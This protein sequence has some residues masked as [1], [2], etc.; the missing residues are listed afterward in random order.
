VTNETRW[1]ARA[2]LD[3]SGE[4][5]RQTH[6]FMAWALCLA[7]AVIMGATQRPRVPLVD[8]GTAVEDAEVAR[9]Q[10]ARLWIALFMGLLAPTC[11]SILITRRRRRGGSHPRGIVIDVT[12]DGELRLWGR[13]YGQRLKLETAT[14][15]ERLVDV[16]AGR[17]GAWRQ[18]RLTITPM[19]GRPLELATVATAEDNDLVLV[20]FGGEGNCVELPREDYLALFELSHDL[21]GRGDARDARS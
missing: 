8:R 11:L 1:E 7:L 14:I 17:L 3:V 20:V 13:G 16:Y 9:S 10:R 2:E 19:R 18:R 4:T 12:H 15:S 5:A 21:S 6:V